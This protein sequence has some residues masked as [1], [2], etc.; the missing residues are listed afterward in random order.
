MPERALKSVG[1]AKEP[2]D[3]PQQRRFPRP[4]AAGYGQKLAGCDGKVH[5][6][7]NVTVAAATGQI[8]SGKPHQ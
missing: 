4:I 6:G 5:A 2:D 8:H 7:E 3:K 1:D